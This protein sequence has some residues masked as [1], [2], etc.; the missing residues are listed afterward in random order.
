MTVL[1][2]RE[3][4][5]LTIES[6]RSTSPD[7]EIVVVD[8]ASKDPVDVK[9]SNV[10]YRRNSSRLGVAK[11]RDIA[12]DMASGDYILIT[13][14]HMRF[15]PDW[16]KNIISRLGDPMQAWNGCCL[17]LDADHMD[18][19]K[20]KGE[21]N[22]A[23]LVLFRDSDKTIFEGKWMSGK[24]GDNYE[25]P[26][27]MGASYFISKE[28]YKKV[29][30][31]GALKLWGSDEPYLASKIWL[32]GGS[33]RMA[34]DVKIGHKFR[35]A[36]PYKS[37]TWCIFYNKLR[38]VREVFGDEWYRFILNQM[39][40]HNPNVRQA[41]IQCIKDFPEIL[42]NREYYQTIFKHDSKWLCDK[43]GQ[44]IYV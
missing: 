34:K 33:I 15:R 41:N 44:K 30:G 37:S 32:A 10:K 36:A 1:E 14:S 13:D 23:N 9:Y 43:F 3:E 18:V 11:S 17:G 25:V 35:K 26:C 31:L 5:N 22:G 12:V 38:G 16:Y 28:L 20:P 8:D 39:E 7:L 27:F 42:K 29:L 24:P 2:D 19:M 4:T 6:I 21:Y 40:K